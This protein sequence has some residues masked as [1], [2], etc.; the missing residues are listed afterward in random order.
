MVVLRRP[1]PER[2]LELGTTRRSAGS[3]KSSTGSTA[4]S[5][6]PAGGVLWYVSNKPLMCRLRAK[7]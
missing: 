3:D 7:S 5:A 1:A 2:K 4:S 6:R